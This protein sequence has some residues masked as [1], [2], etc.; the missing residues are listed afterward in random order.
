MKKIVGVFVCI[1]FLAISVIPSD[2]GAYITSANFLYDPPDNLDQY[3]TL[4]DG[5]A[6]GCYKGNLFAQCFMPRYSTLTRVELLLSNSTW[7]GE[8]LPLTNLTISI[9]SVLEE[10]DLVSYSIEP[11]TLLNGTEW[12]E[13]DFKDIQVTP[14]R[15]Y[16]IVYQP[17]SD[18]DGNTNV[19]WSFSYENAYTHGEAWYYHPD[20]GSWSPNSYQDF[21]FK[22]YGYG[23]TENNPPDKPI[24]HGR[25]IGK[26]GDSYNYTFKSYDDD[27]DYIS[28]YI[29]DWGDGNKSSIT[30]PFEWGLPFP[31]NHTWTK[32]GY[33]LIQAKAID[34]YGGESNW[35]TLGVS[36]SKSKAIYSPLFLH[37]FFNRFPFFEKILNLYHN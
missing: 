7:H 22:T 11:K 34:F 15:R 10:N 16:F 26:V 25:V 9:R 19:Y 8:D 35:A 29:V 32:K 33:Y 1:L 28:K 31:A 13:L 21:C 36:M 14:G 18:F 2:N 5:G 3:Q 37:G 4:D 27:G 24:I 12:F 23:E 20:S 6:Q 30:C 17:G